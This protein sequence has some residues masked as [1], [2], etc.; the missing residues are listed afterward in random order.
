[1]ASSES[2][3]GIALG[4]AIYGGIELLGWAFCSI[5][6]ML[7]T[8]DSIV[9]ILQGGVLVPSHMTAQQLLTFLGG[10]AGRYNAIAWT[11]AFVTQIVYWGAAM[12]G[13]PIKNRTLHRIIVWAFFCLEVVTDLWYSIASDVTIGG[14]VVYVFNFGNGGWLVSLCYIASMSAGSI[15][16]GVR[17]MSH[18]NRSVS[19]VFR[20]EKEA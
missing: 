14:V 3:G 7:T 18:L 13:G 2:G 5:Q 10:N 1:M 20:K 4:M 9:S 16:L 8:H 12:P 19:P 11:V 15:F 17:G 6:Q